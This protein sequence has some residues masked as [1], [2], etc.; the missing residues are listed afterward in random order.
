LHLTLR[1]ITGNPFR[2]G[3]IFACVTVA[4]AFAILGTQVIQGARQNM[5]L[6]L[7]SINS[8]QADIMVFPSRSAY[9]S[10]GVEMMD[11]E[12]LLGELSVIPGVA[13][14]S[15]QIRLSTIQNSPYCKKSEMYLV[16]FDPKTD[17]T[18]MP[19]L[20][21]P[22]QSELGVGES[23]SGCFVTKPQDGETLAL[24]GAKLNLAGQLSSTGTSLDQSL[25][26]TIDTALKLARDPQNQ[27][28][29]KPRIAIDTLPVIL[30]KTSPG[31]NPKNV[32]KDILVQIPFITALE[33]GN[34]FEL[35]R[36]QMVSLLKAIPGLLA[37]IWLLTMV[38]ISLVFSISVNARRREIGVL[39]VLGFTRAFVLK[40]ILK[41]G[42][43][44]AL[45][46]GLV[47]AGVSAFV[48]GYFG[49][50]LGSSL[51][52]PLVLPGI[53]AQFIMVMAVLALAI[54]SVTLA[55]LY[56]AWRISRQE[57]A[58]IIKG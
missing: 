48:L 38:C 32:L 15:P 50:K 12:G 26:V 27:A 16:A 46:G 11:F 9:T 24:P 4:A 56:P 3:L 7:A 18:V 36:S 51:G 43:L 47:G 49:D 45:G 6:S 19:K 17:F 35:E 29:K 37:V 30:V 44:L 5:Q 58:N 23:I 2:S 34:Y 41:E 10:T 1:S 33:G 55:A 39:R 14:V 13:A 31:S 22:L 52:L 53:S 57:P 20:T 8:P 25:F 40:S 28:E 21:T 42:F 54:I